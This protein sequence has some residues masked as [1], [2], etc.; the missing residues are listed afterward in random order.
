[1]IK[2]FSLLSTLILFRYVCNVNCS[3]NLLAF[4]FDN[5]SREGIT[6]RVDV[7]VC[8]CVSIVTECYPG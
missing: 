4:L 1:M 3:R 8:V 2:Q 6:E 5:I 7:H